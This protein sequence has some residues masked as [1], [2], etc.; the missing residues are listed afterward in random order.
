MLKQIDLAN[1]PV[2]LSSQTIVKRG[3]RKLY[4]VVSGRNAWWATWVN[5]YQSGCMHLDLSSAMQHAE[6]LRTNGSVFYIKE[7][8]ALVLQGETSTLVVTQINCEVVLAAY[9]PKGY[10]LRRNNI[11][12]TENHILPGISLSLAASSFARDS[13]YWGVMPPSDDS[14]LIFAADVPL[15]KF[16]IYRESSV[17]QYK[18]NSN[19]GQYLLS[20]SKL[21]FDVK[22]KALRKIIKIRKKTASD[23]VVAKGLCYATT[24]C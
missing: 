16:E 13:G 9:H 5:R 3:V 20:W 22:S 11:K 8:P 19:G 21:P 10:S 1:F 18:S 6:R 17:V 2:S 14:V 15:S 23:A 4:Y 24:P 7:I 12:R